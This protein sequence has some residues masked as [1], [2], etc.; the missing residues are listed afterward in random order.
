MSSAGAS[1]GTVTRP[2]LSVEDQQRLLRMAR[3]AVEAAAR[4]ETLPVAVVEGRLAAPGAAFVTLRRRHDLRGCIGCIEP[5]PAGLAST[6]IA[7]AAAAAREDPR[8]ARVRPAEVPSL[9]VE[10][11]VLGPLVEVFQPGDLVI[12]RDGLV[13]EHLG[14]RGLLLP[15]VPV[16][17]GWDLPTYLAQICRKAGLP[18]DDWQTGARLWRFEA[19][20][21][22]EEGDS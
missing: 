20:V 11:S 7:M 10:V 2:V 12:G 9:S 4:D 8:F 13:I 16:E 15:Q 3:E 19:L 6:V 18:A 17:W 21:F 5:R 14:R 1:E 22:G